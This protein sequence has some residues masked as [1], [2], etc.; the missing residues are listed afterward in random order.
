MAQRVIHWTYGLRDIS[1]LIGEKFNNEVWGRLQEPMDRVSQE[2]NKID[3]DYT[4]KL[5]SE[6]LSN[7]AE[8]VT[9]PS[10]RIIPLNDMISLYAMAEGKNVSESD[11]FDSN[12]EMKP[13]YS[14][15]IAWEGANDGASTEL[16][17]EAVD[18][19]NTNADIKAKV[20]AELDY[21]TKVSNEYFDKAKIEYKKLTG[22][23]LNRL[24]KRW[25]TSL[26]RSNDV[27]HEGD[28][29]AVFDNFDG[30]IPEYK[31]I[32]TP[33]EFNQR[34]GGKGGFVSLDYRNNFLHHVYSMV[35]YQ[36]KA[37]IIKDIMAII[38]NP[39]FTSAMLERF[40]GEDRS[41]INALDF[42][43]RREM[44]PSGKWKR[45][46]GFG[47]R[48]FG[49]MR[50]NVYNSL[51][52]WNVGMFPMQLSSWPM[53]FQELGLNGNTM[54]QMVKNTLWT[55]QKII[56][57]LPKEWKASSVREAFKGWSVWE[58]MNKYGASITRRISN[59]DAEN[60]LRRSRQSWI[61][62]NFKVANSLIEKGNL[63]M[64]AGDMSYV[65]ATWNTMFEMKREQLA[66]EHSSWT[67]EQINRKA[68]LIAS[69]AIM[70]TQSP[71]VIGEKSLLQTGSEL[72]KMQ[73]P[74]SGQAFAVMKS[75]INNQVLPIVEAIK[76]SESTGDVVKN[77][78]KAILT[79]Q[80]AMK[81]LVGVALPA[82]AMGA[83]ARRRRQKD[84][85]ELATDV[86]CYA[87]GTIPIIGNM[88]WMSVALGW[89][90]G[91]PVTFY[92]DL[93]QSVVS[94]TK[95]ALTGDEQGVKKLG[96]AASMIAGSPMLLNKIIEDSIRRYK[97][98][99]SSFT[100]EGMLASLGWKSRD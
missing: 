24:N 78:G 20:E 88:I 89:D 59:P 91:N 8:Q 63:I 28:V 92:E 30:K 35:N 44:S 52:S 54:T 55:M 81:M 99:D 13:R 72:E 86:L 70:N 50:A 45:D 57:G 82:I 69:D 26:M 85:T 73:I 94:G 49:Q 10:G 90:N 37:A 56:S 19:I 95:G 6:F 11:L 96:R 98:H 16:L 39:A 15:I 84:K 3:E 93:F 38:R 40:G 29:D 27:T 71:S 22:K 36:Q 100:G 51:L 18:Y 32:K 80:Y 64:E 58:N 1:K 43:V 60:M 77:V 65:V 23:E 74:F 66:K 25:Y 2:Q 31:G 67:E 9:L 61:A 42:L 5:S 14:D 83:V 4:S 62:K 68:G 47:D 46:T 17:N 33:S 12:G 21:M 76:N 7:T 75:I 53:A 41:I 79:K 34:F 87:L 97:E 48:F